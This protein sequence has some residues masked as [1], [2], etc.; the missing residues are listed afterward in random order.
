MTRPHNHAAFKARVPEPMRIVLGRRRAYAPRMQTHAQI[1]QRWRDLRTMLI[2]QLDLF[3]TGALILRSNGVN[4]SADAVADLKHKI[5]EF[6]A[7]IA[8]DDAENP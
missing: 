6:D 1:V 3:E 8:K 2:Q 7:L 4:I 5:L